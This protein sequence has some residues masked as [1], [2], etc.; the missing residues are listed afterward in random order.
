MRFII[1]ANEDNLPCF[2]QQQLIYIPHEHSFY[3]NGI[4]NRIDIE[5]IVNKI[6]LAVSDNVIVNV[7]G[8]C[9]LDKSMI[10]DCEIP[11]YQKGILKVEHNLEYGFAYGVS[12]NDLSIHVNIHTGWI[13]IGSPEKKGHAVEFIKNCVAVIDDDKS[14]FSIWLKPLKLPYL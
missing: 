9:G 5:L 6:S 13:C 4:V 8:F 7:G 14:L 2:W 3:M 11:K 12:E 10:S 1:G